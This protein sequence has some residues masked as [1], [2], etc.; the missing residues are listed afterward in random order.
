MCPSTVFYLLYFRPA[1]KKSGNLTER[2]IAT[3]LELA[4]FC[5]CGSTLSSFLISCF[6]CFAGLVFFL[7]VVVIKQLQVYLKNR[8]LELKAGMRVLGRL[9]ESKKES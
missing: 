9:D 8:V 4:Y 5:S 2:D 6:F 3:V 1:L 7:K